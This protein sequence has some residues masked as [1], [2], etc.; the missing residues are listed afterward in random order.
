MQTVV[1]R[2]RNKG[3]QTFIHLD[4]IQ[5][6]PPHIMHGFSLQTSGGKI[7]EFLFFPTER[8]F[9]LCFNEIPK[10]LSF[11]L[12]YLSLCKCSRLSVASHDRR[13]M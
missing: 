13:T 10:G 8:L 11:Y 4:G 7:V 3:V 9:S 2:Q 12:E 6:Y 1:R 5:I